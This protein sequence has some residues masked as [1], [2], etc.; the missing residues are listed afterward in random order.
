MKKKIAKTGKKDEE[1]KKP[2]DGEEEEEEKEGDFDPA[3]IEEALDD[4][5]EVAEFNDVDNF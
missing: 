1:V 4:F 2:A 5:D 3:S